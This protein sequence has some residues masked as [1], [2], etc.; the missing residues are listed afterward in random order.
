MQHAVPYI[1]FCYLWLTFINTDIFVQL[2]NVFVITSRLHLVYLQQLM[3]IFQLAPSPLLPG[4]SSVLS[5]YWSHLAV[6]ETIV[7]GEL[8]YNVINSHVLNANLIV[9]ISLVFL[10]GLVLVWRL[11][12][13]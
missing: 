11:Y 1:F 5:A 10:H 6:F 4:Q 3:E 12:K 8:M 13:N 9:L 2:I 7:Y